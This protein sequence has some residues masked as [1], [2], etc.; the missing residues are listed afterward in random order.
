[1]IDGLAMAFLDALAE[2]ETDGTPGEGYDWLFGATKNNA[3]AHR[4]RDYTDFPVWDGVRGS[5]GVT[6]AAGR[7]QFQP[8]TY[9]RMAA[10]LHLPDFSPECQDAAAWQLAQDVYRS[11]EGRD[12]RTDLN[13]GFL[14]RVVPAL[15]STWTSL[16]VKTFPTRFH[17]AIGR[18]RV[19]VAAIPAP[20]LKGVIPEVEKAIRDLQMALK[21]AGFYNA[22]VDGLFG[23][24]SIA[25]VQAYELQRGSGT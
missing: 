17:A 12:L 18:P 21:T 6:H 5:W 8:G 24:R 22:A 9:S 11:Q 2:G 23:P 25:A 14:A 19:T 16:N 10:K 1:M 4:F 3:P 20:V 15:R 13:N 7:Y